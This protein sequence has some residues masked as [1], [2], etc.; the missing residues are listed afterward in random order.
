MNVKGVTHVFQ[1]MVENRPKK[2]CPLKAAENYQAKEVDQII[3]RV[4]GPIIST[5]S[6]WLKMDT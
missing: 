3:S 6:K 1:K 2:R 4:F 5:I